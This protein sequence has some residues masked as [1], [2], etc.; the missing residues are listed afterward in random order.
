LRSKTCRDNEKQPNDVDKVWWNVKMQNHN[1]MQQ[2][3]EDAKIR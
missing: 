3:C 2:Q 1:R